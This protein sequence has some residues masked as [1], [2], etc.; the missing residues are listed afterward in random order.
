MKK[1]TLLLSAMLLAYATN[2]WAG[3]V[4]VYKLN[5]ATTTIATTNSYGSIKAT[6]CKSDDETSEVTTANWKITLGSKQ[7]NNPAG[8]WLGS[9]SKNTNQS[10]ETLGNGSFT[11]A[12]A[13][14]TAV[15][16]KTS[17]KFY[18]AL[19][20]ETELPN[21]S[22][23][24]VSCSG[25]GNQTPTKIWLLASEDGGTTWSV[26][27]NSEKVVTESTFTLSAPI[28]SARYA[29]V[30]YHSAYFSVKVPVLTF[31]KTVSETKTVSVVVAE[32]QEEM[33]SVA[34]SYKADSEV[35]DWT[36]TTEPVEL[37]GEGAEVFQFV[38]TPKDG[39]KFAGWTTTGDIT[40]NDKNAA[41]AVG[42][43]AK[44]T[45]VVTANFERDATL[46]S[47]TISGTATKLNYFVGDTFDPAGLVVIATY[48]DDAE[49]DVTDQVS[50]TLDP[51]TF[52]EAGTVSVEVTAN[53]DA[54]YSETF[55][56]NDIVVVDVDK[57]ALV[58]NSTLLA[59]GQHII[60]ANADATYA[61]ST[62]QKNTNRG[63][64]AITAND[65]VI[66]PTEGVQI[67]TLDSIMVE[68]AIKWELRVA[69]DSYLYAASTKDNHLKTRKGNSGDTQGQ[70]TISIDAK[71]VATV[72]AS[73]TERNWMRYNPNNGS[74]LFSCYKE[75]Q[76]DIAIY[77]RQYTV[78]VVSND[79]NMGSVSGN[80]KYFENNVAEL[81]A[82]PKAGYKLT[83][84]SNNN[85]LTKN[86]QSLVV[87]ENISI[88]AY[89]AKGETAIDNAAAETPAVK[90]I[91]NGQLVIL[92]DGVKYNAMGVRLQ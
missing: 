14:A 80:G 90:T 65:G 59:D 66:V 81:V 10:K 71:G 24:N 89:F 79:E 75:K 42:N 12:T 41:T 27:A 56:V 91:E 30:Y 74:P 58:T 9:N 63:A 78:K 72:K 44:E 76:N 5:T 48:S 23:V 60:I 33:G 73:G 32:G 4:V 17:D 46:T 28:A 3:D 16:A 7:T 69:A 82:T 52:D 18:T 2:L 21:I 50:W 62:E 6:A 83:G 36:A 29:L 22:K 77:A 8:L 43:S 38:A 26:A 57:Y 11:E 45:S 39:Y 19:I 84:W 86:E 31:Y 64:V 67:I 40:L 37:A 25:F 49:D 1:I 88:T 34:M 53:I 92:R 61:L 51:E 20:S 70:W 85:E 15:G 54:I 13:I 87:T 55:T 68:D 35:A 47:L